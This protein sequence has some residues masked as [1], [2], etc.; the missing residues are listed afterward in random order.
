MEGI[1][2]APTALL[3]DGTVLPRHSLLDAEVARVIGLYDHVTRLP[4]R[5]QFIDDYPLLMG[6]GGRLLVLVALSDARHYNDMLQALGHAFADD[7]V[8]DGARLLGERTG[9]AY[10]IYHVGVVSFA[11]VIE[12]TMPGIVP[13]LV[14]DLIAAF[15][16]PIACAGI[17]VRARVAAGMV[18]LDDTMRDPAEALRAA[19]TSARE[20]R[21]KPGA[22][23]FY[24]RRTDAAHGRATRL[25]TDLPEALADADQ[26]SL[27][28]QPRIDMETGLCTGAEAL[29]RWHH[30]HF[31]PVSPGELI[32][33]VDQTALI[34]PLTDWVLDRA[35]ATARG[36]AKG[37]MGLRISVNISPRNLTQPGFADMVMAR[38]AAADHDPAS[39][40]LEF[41]EGALMADIGHTAPVLAALRQ[42]GMTVSIDDFGGGFS[43][44]GELT[45]LPADMIKV[46]PGLVR[47]VGTARSDAFLLRQIIS[48]ARGLGFR[49]CA[50]GIEDRETFVLLQSLGC[51]EGQGYLLGRPMPARDFDLWHRATY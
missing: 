34:R 40:E 24:D 11:L 48:T 45:R 14:A 2:T 18:P 21:T 50:E 27:H 29:L 5:M 23:G 30:P 8:R 51:D 44:L 46:D 20:G 3:A 19:L 13:P 38:C 12:H 25:L 4:N 41:S 22:C 43:A 15:D 28:F 16:E 32:P 36:F 35:I 10:N 33:L 49:A 31:G 39:L 42:H 9:Y 6:R 47:R 26:L 7:F 37:G 1:G 17:P